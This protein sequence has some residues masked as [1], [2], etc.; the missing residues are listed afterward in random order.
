LISRQ[1]IKERISGTYKISDLK[2]P[3]LKYITD[4]SPKDRKKSSNKKKYM[5]IKLHKV[6]EKLIIDY[7]D[8]QMFVL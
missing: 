4:E 5:Y 7:D 2:Y 1:N 8:C 3:R 6:K